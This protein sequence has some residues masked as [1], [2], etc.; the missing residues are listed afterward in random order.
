MR[1]LLLIAA[2]LFVLAPFDAQLWLVGGLRWLWTAPEGRYFA[3]GLLGTLLAAGV[4][5][6]GIW[7]ALAYRIYLDDVAK[8]QDTY[9]RRRR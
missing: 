4:A 2:V 9:K 3:A 6:N 7:N 5:Y 8:A 1:L